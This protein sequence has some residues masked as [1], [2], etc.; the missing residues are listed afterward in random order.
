MDGQTEGTKHYGW[1][2]RSVLKVLHVRVLYSCVDMMN[3]AEI[4]PL[5][6][7]D[8]EKQIDLKNWKLVYVHTFGGQKG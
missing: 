2:N 1:S 6:L 3:V 4:R 7:G 5:M 8:W